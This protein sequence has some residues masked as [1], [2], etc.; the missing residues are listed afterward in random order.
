MTEDLPS[1]VEAVAARF[2]D[3]VESLSIVI[4][5]ASVCVG[6]KYTRDYRSYDIH[7]GGDNCKA[8]IEDM[9]FQVQ[10]RPPG[11]E[12][13]NTVINASYLFLGMGTAILHY[14]CYDVL[15]R[16][17]TKNKVLPMR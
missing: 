15:T 11:K 10:Q 1:E 6:K 4:R 9:C 3:G 17:R 8:V 13:S 5:E 7:G 12:V 16:K 14:L 2:C